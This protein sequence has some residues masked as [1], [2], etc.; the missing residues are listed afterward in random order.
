MLYL[1]LLDLHLSQTPVNEDSVLS[2][3]DLVEKNEQLSYNDKISFLN[4]KVLFLEQNSSSIH[5]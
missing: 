4:R 3:F 5:R 1:Q 2:V